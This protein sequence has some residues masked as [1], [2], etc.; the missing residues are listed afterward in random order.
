MG[1]GSEFVG[2][3]HTNLMELIMYAQ[4]SVSSSWTCFN[5]V[6]RVL[7]DDKRVA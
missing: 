6:A 3:G 5:N 1:E 7:L 4:W 2:E